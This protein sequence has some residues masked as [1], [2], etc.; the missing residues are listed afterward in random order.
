M[1]KKRGRYVEGV[2]LHTK[3]KG[4]NLELT[5]RIPRKAVREVFP[6][7]ERFVKAWKKQGQ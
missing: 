5:F 7:I 4:K 3:S 2:E 1:K 6:H